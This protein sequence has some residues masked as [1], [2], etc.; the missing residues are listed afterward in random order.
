MPT[1]LA[2]LAGGLLNSL[3]SSIGAAASK[4]IQWIPGPAQYRRG[5][6]NEITHKMLDLQNAIPFDVHQ[7]NVLRQQ[8]DKLEADA[9]NAGQ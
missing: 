9:V 8:R 5:K 1:W 2:S 7:Y 4:G 3:G 6:I